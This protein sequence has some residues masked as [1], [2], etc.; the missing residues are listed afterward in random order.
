MSSTESLSTVSEQYSLSEKY[1][2]SEQ[3]SLSEH[4]IFLLPK[5][6]VFLNKKETLQFLRLGSILTVKIARSL[7]Y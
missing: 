6:I 5:I 7:F 1:S 2:L 4:Y 3:Y